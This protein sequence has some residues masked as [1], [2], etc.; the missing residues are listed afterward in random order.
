MSVD[1]DNS[2]YISNLKRQS[3]RLRDNLDVPLN[4]ARLWL[5]KFI[6]QEKD[7]SEIQ[8]KIR[9]NDFDGYI[10]LSKI[11]P[12]CDRAIYDK[13]CTEK[14][15]IIRR[16]ESSPAAEKF[17]GNLIVLLDKVFGV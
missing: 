14:V 3:L 9:N 13:F 15:H 17:G 16:L 8:R 11:E 10:Y 7:I 5:A 6:Y 1:Q 4:V 2:R 12:R